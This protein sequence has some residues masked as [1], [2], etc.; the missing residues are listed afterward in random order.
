[1]FP[2]GA[3]QQF[4]NQTNFGLGTYVEF[5]HQTEYVMQWNLGIARE[6]TSTLSLTI[7]YVGSV[8][9]TFPTARQHSIMVLPTLTP[10][11]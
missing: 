11:G 9:F 1:M 5:R 2:T 7:G 4:S 6:L 8:E 10:A 3:F